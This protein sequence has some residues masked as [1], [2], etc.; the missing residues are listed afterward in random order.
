MR[1]PLSLFSQLNRTIV[2]GVLSRDVS[3]ADD[4]GRSRWS[5]RKS[6]VSTSPLPPGEFPPAPDPFNCLGPVEKLCVRIRVCMDALQRARD[7]LSDPTCISKGYTRRQINEAMSAL[8]R[9]RLDLIDV[10]EPDEDDDDDDLADT[11]IVTGATD[12]GFKRTSDQLS[13][14]GA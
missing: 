4:D 13:K 11:P 1:P 12:E 10:E 7:S 14:G 3:A 5:A 9:A 2:R 6:T 8:H